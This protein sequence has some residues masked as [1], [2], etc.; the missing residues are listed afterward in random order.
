MSIVSIF[1]KLNPSDP[2]TLSKSVKDAIMAFFRFFDSNGNGIIEQFE[3]SEIFT[4]IISG[5][6]NILASLIDHFEP[7]I[8]KARDT[9]PAYPAF[10]FD[11]SLLNVDK[12]AGNTGAA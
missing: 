2:E 3:L 9:D 1:L 11:S 12:H 6:A 5:I 10:H 4:D 8:L 7:F